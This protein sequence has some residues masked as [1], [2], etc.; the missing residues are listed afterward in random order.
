MRSA[1]WFLVASFLP[2]LP[3]EAQNAP[4]EASR[5]GPTPARVDEGGIV[6]FARSSVAQRQGDA[7]LLAYTENGPGGRSTLRSAWLRLENGGLVRAREDLTL[8][9]DAR[10]LA[11]AWT[12]ERG[13]LAYVVPRR[14]P[15]LVPGAPVRR[16]TPAVGVP[17]S[18]D[19]PLGPSNL[20]G[21]DLMVQR[22]DGEGRP[23]GAPVTVF[24]ENARLGLVRAAWVGD[25][26]VVA[27]AGA[28]VTDDE[29]RTTVRLRTISR[30]G[31]PLRAFAT[32]TGLTGDV[33]D[34]L[35]IVPRDD[36]GLDLVLSAIA[37]GSEV[38]AGEAISPP[39]DPSAE[40]EAPRRVLMP[41]QAPR[42]APGPP[43]GC[44]PLALHRIRLDANDRVL[45]RRELSPLA[46][47]LAARAGDRW[48]V[49][50]PVGET[51]IFAAGRLT[52]E[53]LELRG[54]GGDSLEVHARTP[55]A[56]VL[57]LRRRPDEDPAL[58]EHPLAPPEDDA[59]ALLGIGTG[60]AV[61]VSRDRR[62][63][64]WHAE[65]G[66]EGVILA[67][68]VAP[69]AEVSVL[70]GASPWIVLREGIWSGPVR[71]LTPAHRAPQ[72]WP[73]TMPVSVSARPPPPNP[74][75]WDESFAR[76]WV[77]ART[78]RAIFM[79]HEN[80]AGALAARPEA[81]TDPRMPAV[82][83]NRTRLR[84]RWETACGALQTRASQLARRGAGGEVT[85]AVQQLCEIHADLQLGVPIN[86]AL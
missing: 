71:W 66:D 36:G 83:A 8:A 25:R 14:P 55:R 31:V 78:A 33:G 80:S 65:G 59:V 21:G 85:Q 19:D 37:C 57:S 62:V 58:A 52:G 69:I 74:Y 34:A 2:G 60:G 35:E 39:A 68:A 23:Q 30:E 72:P 40:I 20:S 48:L 64:R 3:A 10:T 70:D 76:L 53:R 46:A 16:R 38:P 4:A 24:T 6:A 63:L 1:V 51:A 50:V 9:P 7:L 54:P 22:L 12:G 43:L 41:Q 61:R 84:Q 15:P 13:A 18:T 77:R 75:V 56:Q 86:P 29:V 67:R 81:P 82:I 47:D 49:R 11:L 79:R 44:G 26:L 27:W 32:H 28:T 73:R 17:A 42:D 5:A 45:E